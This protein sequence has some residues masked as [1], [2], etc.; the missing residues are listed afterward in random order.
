[1]RLRLVRLEPGELDHEVLW[2]SVGTLAFGLASAWLIWLGPPAVAC[3]FHWLTGLPCLSC[4]STRALASLL[5]GDLQS[6]LHYH[7]AVAP[8]VALGAAGWVYAW[9]VVALDLPRVR[10]QAAGQ[11]ARVLR[12]AVVV[13]AGGLWVAQ[14]ARGV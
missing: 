13:G 9:A 11:A 8:G 2:A 5:E 14:I 6:S 1:M 7:P 12:W 3:P 10:I 4:G